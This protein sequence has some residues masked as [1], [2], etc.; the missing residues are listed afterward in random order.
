MQSEVRKEALTKF[1]EKDIRCCIA[2]HSGRKRRDVCVA[3]TEEEIVIRQIAV[4]DLNGSGGVW[5][6]L[7]IECDHTGV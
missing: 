6:G 3:D 1:K 4:R 7:Q 2:A 5:L